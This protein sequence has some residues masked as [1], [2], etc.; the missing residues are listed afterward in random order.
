MTTR[1]KPVGE[2]HMVTCEKCGLLVGWTRQPLPR[3]FYCIPDFDAVA[4]IPDDASE[5]AS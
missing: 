1:P 5:V 3:P 2:W 4:H